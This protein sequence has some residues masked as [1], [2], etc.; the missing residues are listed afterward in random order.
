MT[1]F[2]LNTFFGGGDPHLRLI[3]GQRGRAQSGGMR[4]VRDAFEGADCVFL[5]A[6]TALRLRLYGNYALQRCAAGGWLLH[7]RDSAA[8][9]YW[10]PAPAML[11]RISTQGHILEERSAEWGE[12]DLDS[13]GVT[14]AFTAIPEGWALDTVIWKLDDPV[15]IKELME[16]SHVETQGYFLLGSH[17]RYGKPADL[18]RHLIHGWVYEDRYAWPHKRRICS[19]NDA[20]ALHLVFSGLERATAKRIY[21]LLKNQLL[22]SVLSR[23]SEDGGFR[24]GEWTDKMESHYRLHCSAMHLMMD[25]LSEIDDP[26]VQTALA[27]GMHF[28]SD[29]CDSTDAGTWFYHDELELTETGMNCAPFKWLPGQALGKSFHN[30][31]VLN[32]HLDILI[33]LDRYSQLSCDTQYAPLV[34][35]GVKSAHAVLALRSAEWFYRLLFS[36]INLTLLPTA[37]AMRLP[38]WKRMW[39]RIGWQVFIPNLYRIKNRF[40]RLV[41]PGG[42]IDRHLGLGSWAFH[43]HTVN[44]MDLVRAR[45][46]FGGT[47]FDAAISEA[48]QFAQASGVRERWKELKYE[49]YALGFW[50]EALW[51]L[52]REFPDHAE[53]RGWYEEACADLAFMNMGMPPSS[54]GG[55]AEAALAHPPT[56]RPEICYTAGVILTTIP[57][58]IGL[59]APFFMPEIGGANLYCYELARALGGLGHEVHVFSI[60]GALED[61]AYRL[62]PVLTRTLEEDISMLLQHDMDVWHS[63]FFYHAPLALHRPNVFVTVH[64]D[65]GFSF[66]LHLRLPGRAA[67]TRHLL[68]RL[69]NRLKSAVGTAINYMEDV[70]NRRVYQ[71]AVDKLAGIVTVSSFTR[72]RFGERYRGA[73]N[74]SAVIPPGVSERFF[75]PHPGYHPLTHLLTVTRLDEGDRIKNVHNVIAALGRLKDR[76]DF[77][78]QIVSGTVTG[79]YRTELE[80]M[81]RD[82]GLTERVA[83]VGRKTDAELLDLYHDT[84]LFILVSYSEAKNFEGFGIVFL[85]ANACGVPVL[86]SRDGGMRDYVVDGENGIYVDTPDA[87]GI[88]AAL[89]RYFEGRDRFDADAIRAKPEPYRWVHIAKRVVAFYQDKLR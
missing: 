68:W 59:I 7:S 36:A 82:L 51:H 8:P 38:L 63:L 57:M 67:L 86:T 21:E 40:P 25:A 65:D 87:D 58:R 37:Q 79:G 61:P 69:P 44:L 50:A 32:T 28:I 83:L 70:Y 76:Y 46:R 64:G 85:E 42:Y 18:Y 5:R 26:V 29:K 55:N 75:A 41:M 30:M 2:D 53:Y 24:H 4:R 73:A 56:L 35:S 9:S 88:E 19:E 54:L 11:R 66:Q 6:D 14:I 62:H 16:F 3:H 89:V 81:I 52:C 60:P 17:T 45:R 15:L 49:R 72:D 12:F 31:L 78:Y 39:K 22:L 74:K 20:H 1:E 33:A 34:D 84:G 71:Q 47:Q 77:Y 10:L 27:H 13:S 23:Q 48:A 80:S 43:Y